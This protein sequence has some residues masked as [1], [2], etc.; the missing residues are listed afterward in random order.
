[1]LKFGNKFSSKKEILDNVWKENSGFEIR[2]LR[3]MIVSFEK[4][5][6]N[7]S[8]SIIKAKA[9]EIILEN[10]ML[11]VN[12]ANIFQCRITGNGLMRELQRGWHDEYIDQGFL[13]DEIKKT[14]ELSHC[15]VLSVYSDF[16][17]VSPN[18]TLLLKVGFSGLLKRAE[19]FLSKDGLTEKQQDFYLSV[20]ISLKAVISFIK[21][22]AKE[23]NNIDKVNAEALKNISVGAPKNT[24]EALQL[25]LVY[26][27]LHDQI[28][29][30]RI[31]TLGRLDVL[32]YPFFKS[33]IDNG[34]FTQI[35][36]KEMLQYFLFTLWS[37]KIPQ[38]V[39][40]CLCGL[41]SQGEDVTNEITYLIIEAY[42]E[43]NIHSPKIHIRTCPKTPKD[44]IKL[45]LR[46]IKDGNS[47]FVFVNDEVAIKSLANVGI[48]KSDATN[49]VL[50]GCYEPCSWGNE[51]GC[52]GAGSINLVKAIEFVFTNGRDLRTNKL[53]GVDTGKIESYDDFERAVKIQIENMA[54]FSM[55]VLNKIEKYYGVVNPEPI[56]SSMYDDSMLAGKD[57][58][59]G[60]AKYNNTAI[61]FT[62]IASLCDSLLA[63][64]RNVFE[65]RLISFEQLREV[66]KNNWQGNELLRAKMLALPEKYG[67]NNYEADL[68]VQRWSAFVA[69]TILNKPNCRGGVYKPGLFSINTCFSCGKNTMATP[70]GRLAETST[71]KNSCAYFGMDKKGITSLINSVTKTD[72]SL[73]PNGSVLD[74]VLHPSAVSGEDG[75]EALREI[76]LTYMRKGGFAIQC[77]IFSGEDLRKAQENPLEYKNLQVRVCGWNAY[78]VNLSKEEQEA[79]IKQVESI[80]YLNTQNSWTKIL[81][82]I[83]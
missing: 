17:H 48:E 82:I 6:I 61:N 23:T 22:L 4:N 66:L 70:D 55:E 47:S 40:F 2:Q 21:R 58:Y 20:V 30:T 76:V 39:P 59:Y 27:Y 10:G 26:F 24:Y 28:A 49:Y 79:F 54:Q 3:E 41:N 52:T 71:S 12:P 29:M 69:N 36:I 35:Q 43:L 25:L 38:D 77:N 50:I 37:F 18:T 51:I 5:N 45:V 34:V 1:M 32:L 63:V 53:L 33:D 81:Q 7:V 8:K 13:V 67:N 73:Y 78:F 56:L 75:L 72:F 14:I 9:L 31:R 11:S 19:E 46:C 68:L 16:G 15:G 65:E 42:S 60:T 74:I 57:V 62:G 83:I 80:D 44:I 64:K